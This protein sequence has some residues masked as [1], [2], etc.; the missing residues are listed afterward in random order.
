[1][2]DGPHVVDEVYC[3]AAAQLASRKCEVWSCE[4]LKEFADST[5]PAETTVRNFSDSC[6]GKAAELKDVTSNRA[7]RKINSHVYGP[8][9]SDRGIRRC[10]PKSKTADACAITSVEWNSTV[11]RPPSPEEIAKGISTIS[12]VYRDSRWW[13]CESSFDGASSL[14][15]HFM[16]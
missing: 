11:H 6:P 15:L 3:G 5:I 4:F 12:G 16:H 1:M 7:T 8:T 10:L 14:G 9:A 2:T 13:L